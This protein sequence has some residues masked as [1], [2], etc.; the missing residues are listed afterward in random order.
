MRNPMAS[1]EGRIPARLNRRGCSG[2]SGAPAGAIA[3]ASGLGGLAGLD[4]G[5]AARGAE[6]EVLP[7]R[8]TPET[9]RSVIKG[10]DFLAG[11][12]AEDGA[13]IVG[14]GEAYPVA[15]TGL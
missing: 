15:M 10:M 3:V 13:W 2:R 5:P 14:G 8:V 12:Q 9:L 1:I 11:R 6:K 4:L 7:K